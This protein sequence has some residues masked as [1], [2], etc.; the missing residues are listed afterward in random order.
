MI[1]LYYWIILNGYKIIFFL[2]E[3]GL[4]YVIYLINISQGDQFQVDFLK[5]LLNNKIFVIV[6]C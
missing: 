4:F 1:D 3:I 2:E 5:V 6:D